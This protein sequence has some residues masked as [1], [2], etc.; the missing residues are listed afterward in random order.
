MT[1]AFVA[2]TTIDRPA[3]AVWARLTDWNAAREW[4]PGVDA[5]PPQ[6][7]SVAGT[8]LVFTA[9]GKRRTAQI[10]SLREGRSVTLRS[11]RCGVTAD[12]RYDCAPAAGGTR[13]SLEAD[14][15]FRGPVRLFGPMIRRAV[16]KA[17]GG[18][19]DTFAATFPPA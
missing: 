6:G 14:L 19:L 2:E 11:T 9:G 7:P 16:R 3:E 5:L 1:K 18:Q 12:Y 8:T 17:D 15:S 13:V 10:S 4:M